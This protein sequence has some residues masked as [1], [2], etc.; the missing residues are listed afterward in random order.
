MSH[1]RDTSPKPYG[2]VAE[3]ATGEDLLKATQKAYDEG[4]RKMEGYSPIPVHGLTDALGHK[5]NRLGWFVF[6][7]GMVGALLGLKLQWWTSTGF[8][9][10]DLF[11]WWPMLE[12]FVAYSGLNGYAHNTGGKPLF[13][14]PAFIPVTF[15]LTILLSGLTAAIAMF[16]MNGLPKPHHPI[17]NAEC[18]ARASSDRFILCIEATDPLYK[19]EETEAFCRE[20]NPLSIEKVET[21]E[22]Y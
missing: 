21:S 7:A 17:F 12:S 19:E 8:R 11:N 20:L 9:V 22:G 10:S 16:A 5:D 4:Y 1:G 2:I 18:M 13:S 3:F 15:E 14:L 6:G